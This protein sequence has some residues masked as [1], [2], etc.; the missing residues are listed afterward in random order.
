VFQYF[1]RYAVGK[2]ESETVVLDIVD[3]LIS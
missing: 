2:A 1:R 3:W